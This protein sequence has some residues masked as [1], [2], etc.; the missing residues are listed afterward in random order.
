[1]FATVVAEFAIYVVKLTISVD[2]KDAYRAT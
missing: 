1:L 2:G